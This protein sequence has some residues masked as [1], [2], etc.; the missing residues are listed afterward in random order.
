MVNPLSFTI[1]RVRRAVRPEVARD[2]IERRLVP[3]ILTGDQGSEHITG[4]VIDLPAG[5]YD[6]KHTL[7]IRARI[8]AFNRERYGMSPKQTAGWLARVQQLADV[9]ATRP[10]S[11]TVG[12]KKLLALPSVPL[13]PAAQLGPSRVSKSSRFR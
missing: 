6:P 5:S 13:A 11:T 3:R 2:A 7:R 12:G 9:V 4:T 1:S 10:A 8:E